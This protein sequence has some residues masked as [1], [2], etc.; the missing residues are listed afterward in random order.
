MF[1]SHY[2][3]PTPAIADPEGNG[4]IAIGADLM[5][6]T[7]LHAYSQGLFPWFNEDE[8]IMWW[9]PNPRCVFY[10]QDFIAKKSLKKTIKKNNY[11]LT[12]NTAFSDVIHHCATSRQE[13]T[14]ISPD[15]INAYTKLNELNYAFSIEV[16]DSP[17]SF[18]SSED[19]LL[20]KK[21][22]DITNESTLVGGLYGLKIGQA[23]FGESM[24]HKQT[25]CS[26]IAFFF[27]TQLA[28]VTDVQLIDCQV[29]SDHLMSLGALTIDRQTFLNHSQA[30]CKK[31]S[32][33]WQQ[34]TKQTLWLP[35]SLLLDASEFSK[36]ILK[37]YP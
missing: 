33:D 23:F 25:D 20:S 3:F 2:T 7:L 31:S 35:A 27:L 12:I 16:W 10:P 18:Y 37:Y 1:E 21:N 32:R 30:L 9:S 4:V 19:H 34:L 6:D 13:G 28:N 15:I 26:K 36:Q 29:E 14:W 8:P 24:F 22:N 17:N 11:W 5:P